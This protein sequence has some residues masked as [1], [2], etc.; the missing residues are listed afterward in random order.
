MLEC[1]IYQ[2]S[3]ANKTVQDGDKLITLGGETILASV[4]NKDDNQQNIS[5]VPALDASKINVTEAPI[6]ATNGDVVYVIDGLVMPSFYK[7]DLFDV[8]IAS[9]LT[10]SVEWM[11]RGSLEG[12]ARES[13]DFTLFI[14]SNEAFETLAPE[15]RQA[16]EA[17]NDFMML[18]LVSHVSPSLYPTKLLREEKIT[19][20]EGLTDG[21]YLY[22]SYPDKETIA[23]GLENSVKANI[24]LADQLSRNGIFHVIDRILVPGN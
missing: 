7:F 4:G 21:T 5:F 6:M 13:N 3:K 9:N 23:I 10:H 1:H 24:I 15:T 14:P 17:S 19:Q 8:L 12:V 18:V 11:Q 22:V 2:G 20:I 16:M